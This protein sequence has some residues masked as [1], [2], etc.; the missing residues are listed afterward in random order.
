MAMRVLSPEAKCEYAGCASKATTIVFY[1]MDSKCVH[2]DVLMLVC[3]E[4]ICVVEEDS[5]EYTIRCENCGCVQG[6]N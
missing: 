2:H 6:V 1:R 5:P 3:D 4:H